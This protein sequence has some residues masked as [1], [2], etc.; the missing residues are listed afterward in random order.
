MTHNR[1]INTQPGS[2]S[3]SQPDSQ[4]R[5]TPKAREQSAYSQQD[6]VS[7]WSSQGSNCTRHKTGRRGSAGTRENH[8]RSTSLCD[9]TGG[10]GQN[11]HHSTTTKRV[12][13]FDRKRSRSDAKDWRVKRPSCT[14]ASHSTPKKSRTTHHADIINISD[15]PMSSNSDIT[16]LPLSPANNVGAVILNIINEQNNNPGNSGRTDTNPNSTEHFCARAGLTER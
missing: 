8:Q 7:T 5:V 4:F 15:V 13:W 1:E 12:T 14:S 3:H 9:P 16:E 11:D 6:K 10:G 2:L